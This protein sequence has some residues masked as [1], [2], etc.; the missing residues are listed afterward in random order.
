MKSVQAIF[1]KQALDMFKNKEVLIQF[2]IFPL[3]AF[4]MTE[5]VAKKNTDIPYNMFVLMMSSIFTGMALLTTMS[6][7][8]AEDKERKSLRFLV[9]AG[10]KPYEYL[11]GIGGVIFTA[12]M[13][14]SLTFGLMGNFSPENFGKFIAVMMLGAVASIL[15]GS[16]IG[17][18][19]KN[20]QAA[21]GL[22]MP[23]AM[24]LGFS[25]MI[26]MFNE[27][28]KKIFSILYTHQ[29]N[30]VVND[31]SANLIKPL[32]VM[33]ANIIVLLI[34]FVVA[35]TKKGLKN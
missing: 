7:I 25:P 23:L 9:I 26:A 20:Q 8:I 27:T 32:L 17:I 11:L 6:S 14:V 30:V 34:L 5:L 28:A 31:F 3:V 18:I 16:T 24:L 10:V 19:S 33:L 4:V 2:I 13:L 1:T 29:L 21:I 15:L 22:A 35:Y 12:S